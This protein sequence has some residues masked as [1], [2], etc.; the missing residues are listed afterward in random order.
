MNDLREKND[1]DQDGAEMTGKDRHEGSQS[2]YQ[3]LE[4]YLLLLYQAYLKQEAMLEPEIRAAI[5]R[6]VQLREDFPIKIR[7]MQL[8]LLNYET[9]DFNGEWNQVKDSLFP[10]KD[11]TV[12]DSLPAPREAQIRAYKL[13]ITELLQSIH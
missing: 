3:K 12:L 5:W 6:M 9:D 2:Y 7:M 10:I 13:E 8:Q 1:K 11:D 4:A